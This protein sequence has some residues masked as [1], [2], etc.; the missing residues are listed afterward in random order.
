MSKILNCVIFDIQPR[1][2]ILEVVIFKYV[3]LFFSRNF[4]FKIRPQIVPDLTI[5]VEIIKNFGNVRKVKSK[6]GMR[7]HGRWF[8]QIF[9]GIKKCLARTQFSKTNNG[10]CLFVCMF[11]Q[12]FI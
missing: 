9:R 11:F 3:E 10:F 4:N 1:V 2:L 5:R 12:L 6:F 7:Q 8:V